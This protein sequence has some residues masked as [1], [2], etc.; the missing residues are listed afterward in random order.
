MHKNTPGFLPFPSHRYQITHP[1]FRR[2]YSAKCGRMTGPKRIFVADF[3]A[4]QMGLNFV[5]FWL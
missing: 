5:C 2:M 3:D 1:D 4:G